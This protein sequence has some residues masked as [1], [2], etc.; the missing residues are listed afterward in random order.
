MCVGTH[1]DPGYISLMITVLLSLMTGS[2]LIVF[3]AFQGIGGGGK[4]IPRAYILRPNRAL[5]Q[6]SLWSSSCMYLPVFYCM[7]KLKY[8]VS[9]SDI[10]SL[11][12][13]GKYQGINEGV[14]ALSNGLGPILGGIFAEYTTWSVATH[15]LFVCTVDACGLQ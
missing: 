10:V 2:Q 14:I 4:Q 7:L 3:R 13:R 12:D 1:D 11:K 5:Q 15:Y 6:S 9:V 8:T